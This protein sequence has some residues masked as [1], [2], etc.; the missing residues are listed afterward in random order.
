MDSG[1]DPEDREGTVAVMEISV[2][3]EVG[4]TGCPMGSEEGRFHGC[5]CLASVGDGEVVE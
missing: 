1:V 2:L 4:M 5:R 3:G